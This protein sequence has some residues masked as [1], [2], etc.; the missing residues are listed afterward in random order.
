[1]LGP[2][3]SELQRRSAINKVNL[4]SHL[5]ILKRV[6]RLEGEWEC[7]LILGINERLI[8]KSSLNNPQRG[9]RDEITFNWPT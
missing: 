9:A 4:T 5:I 7:R 6:A 1:M 3:S 8:F 2:P